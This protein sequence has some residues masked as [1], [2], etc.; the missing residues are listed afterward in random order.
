MPPISPH[1]PEAVVFDFDGTLAELV[2]DFTAMKAR[3]T[4][5]ARA[6]LADV[7]PPDGLPALEYADQLAARIRATTPGDATAFLRDVARAIMEQE[8]EAAGQA[9]LFPHTRAALAALA[10]K[11][12]PTGIITRNCR[13]AVDRIFPDAATHVGVILARDDTPHVKPD[14]RHLLTALAALGATPARSLMVGDHPMDLATGRAAGTL[15][16]GVA[17]GRVP[18]GELATHAPDY[19]AGDV[20]ELVGML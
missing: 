4:N 7:P 11:G 14:P 10:A 1:L 2:L 16:A 3:V 17:S 15:T 12:I 19:L 13:A 8:I 5:A 18:R 20:G 9:A 6:Y